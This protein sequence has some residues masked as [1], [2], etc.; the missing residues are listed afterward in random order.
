MVCETHC[1]DHQ[2]TINICEAPLPESTHGWKDSLYAK[3]AGYRLKSPLLKLDLPAGA[4]KGSAGVTQTELKHVRAS[5]VSDY[6][7]FRF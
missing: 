1:S 6:P 2:C 3:K 5:H 4:A 7:L